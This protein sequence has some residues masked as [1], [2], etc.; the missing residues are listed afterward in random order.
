MPKKIHVIPHQGEWAVR[1]NSV[2]RPAK[3]F[4]KK[5]EAVKWGRAMAK[6]EKTEFVIHGRDGKVQNSDSYGH[7]PCPP[8]DKVR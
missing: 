4:E 7:D 2:G 5:A 8:K 3:L 1:H 6:K